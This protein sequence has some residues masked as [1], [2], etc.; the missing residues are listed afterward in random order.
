MQATSCCRGDVKQK[1]HGPQ[2]VGLER[3][4]DLK[5]ITRPL[6][7]SAEVR[8]GGGEKFT[9]PHP[10]FPTGRGVFWATLFTACSLGGIP[11]G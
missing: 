10:A 8:P 6:Q 5:I 2:S 11:G 3:I 7:P 9:D 1:A 4:R